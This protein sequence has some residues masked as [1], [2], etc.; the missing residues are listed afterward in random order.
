MLLCM[1]YAMFYVYLS[2]YVIVVGCSVNGSSR[3][4][5]LICGKVGKLK[6]N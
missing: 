5:S 4:R 3:P 2:E 1:L 6:T